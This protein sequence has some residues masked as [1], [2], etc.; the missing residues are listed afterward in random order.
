MEQIVLIISFLFFFILNL[1]L[2]R[3][4]HFSR[5]AMKE[6]FSEVAFQTIESLKRPYFPLPLSI[7]VGT[8]LITLLILFFLKPSFHSQANPSRLIP[9][10]IHP[11]FDF[12]ENSSSFD[13][14]ENPCKPP[15]KTKK[16]VLFFPPCV[17]WMCYRGLFDFVPLELNFTNLSSLI[18]VS[19]Y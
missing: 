18:G 7:L 13:F 15:W 4:T 3:V 9:N 14:R 19:T 2:K 11:P 10:K 16:I 8:N 6:P 17:F 1:K 5:S 12:P